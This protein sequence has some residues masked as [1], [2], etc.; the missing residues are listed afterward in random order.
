LLQKVGT[1]FDIEQDPDPVFRG[2][3]LIVFLKVGPGSDPKFSGSIKLSLTSTLVKKIVF[4]STITKIELHR[5]YL[6]PNGYSALVL[7]LIDF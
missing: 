4:L 2:R 7:V 5:F 1:K 6:E 3:I